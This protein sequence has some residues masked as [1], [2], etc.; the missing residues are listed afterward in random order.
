MRAYE[1]HR[2]R[3]YI[4]PH[5]HQPKTSAARCQCTMA[6]QFH[7]HSNFPTAAGLPDSNGC[8][9]APVMTQH[10]GRKT[11]NTKHACF[12]QNRLCTGADKPK[13]WLGAGWWGYFIFLKVEGS[14][15]TLQPNNQMSHTDSM[16]ASFKVQLDLDAISSSMSFQY[17]NKQKQTCTTWSAA[18]VTG[19][20]YNVLRIVLAH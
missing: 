7:S 18:Q 2:D 17:N 20:S 5:R 4:L 9:T 1:L 3:I 11:C 13:L 10:I 14:S 8:C 15:K 16:S 12:F 19:R 6:A